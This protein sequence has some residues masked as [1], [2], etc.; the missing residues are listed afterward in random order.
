M[1]IGEGSNKSWKV[2]HL[3]MWRMGIGK[4]DIQL[5]LNVCLTLHNKLLTNIFLAKGK[6]TNLYKIGQR[7][8]QHFPES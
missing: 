3:H 1:Q 2:N 8:Q 7:K 6:R 5:E 4:T